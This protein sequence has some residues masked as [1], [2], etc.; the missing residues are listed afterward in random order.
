M[1]L[2]SAVLTWPLNGAI[3]PL[4]TDS[5][6]VRSVNGSCCS[7]AA[8]L[9]AV[10]A[11]AAT[12]ASAATTDCARHAV[13]RQANRPRGLKVKR[14]MA[15]PIVI[16]MVRPASRVGRPSVRAIISTGQKS[17]RAAILGPRV[18]NGFTHARSPRRFQKL[19]HTARTVAGAARCRPDTQARQQPGAD[20]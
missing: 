5:K 14:G 3:K 18:S 15:S 20:G 1:T 11:L 10:R 4:L 17:F 6:S 13:I 9:A 12:G 16:V 8:L 7:T 19:R 2:P